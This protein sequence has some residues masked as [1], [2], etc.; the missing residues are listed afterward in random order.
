M[1]QEFFKRIREGYLNIWKE[2]TNRVALIEGDK[3]A[4][5]LHEEILK[6]LLPKLKDNA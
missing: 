2:N 4:E 5:E 3:S 1:D 6:I